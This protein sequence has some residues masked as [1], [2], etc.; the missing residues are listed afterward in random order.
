MAWWQIGLILCA[1]FICKAPIGEL[2]Y[3][4]LLLIGMIFGC[5]G[6]L[7]GDI[8][9]MLECIC[10]AFSESRLFQ[11]I[12]IMVAVFGGIL[13]AAYISHMHVV[14]AIPQ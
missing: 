8:P 7:L 10:E 14:H 13:L 12:V 5:L 9:E 11:T 4:L 3:G 6:E 1:L 2:L